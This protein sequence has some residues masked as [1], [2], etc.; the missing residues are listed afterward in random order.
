[1]IYP[2][3]KDEVCYSPR[4]LFFEDVISIL[5]VI[6]VFWRKGLIAFLLHQKFWSYEKFQQFLKIG[7]IQDIQAEMI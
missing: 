5:I 7:G 4:R 1:M 2:L 3:W 6:Q